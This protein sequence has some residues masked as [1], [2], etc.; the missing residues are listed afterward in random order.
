MADAEA[1]ARW[2]LERAAGVFRML[3]VTEV[4]RVLVE[5]DELE[6]AEDVLGQLADPLASRQ[7]DVPR[8]LFARGQLRGAQ[9]RLQEAF[10]DLVECGQRCERLGLP[11]VSAVVWRAEA[12]VV[13]AALGDLEE[14]RRLAGE[15][16]ELA[17]ARSGAHGGWGSRCARAG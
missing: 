11:V 12:A 3:A 5:R 17:R 16:L 1:D 8:F 14:A 2:A 7:V 10:D 9:G 4:V 6:A 13:C 15:Q